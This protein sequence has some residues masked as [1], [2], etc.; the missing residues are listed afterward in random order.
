MSNSSPGKL[1]NH[2]FVF[3]IF[4]GQ[5]LQISTFID[6]FIRGNERE[7]LDY[8]FCHTLFDRSPVLRYI[9]LVTFRKP[10][11]SYIYLSE[12]QLLRQPQEAAFV[13]GTYIFKIFISILISFCLFV[14]FLLGQN[15]D[16]RLYKSDF[17][18]F[19]S[20]FSEC[21]YISFLIISD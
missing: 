6:Q 5:I 2:P 9:W 16:F 11:H 18:L 10:T 12:L 19:F 17:S 4:R 3:F 15:V 7:N 8:L 13:G 1:A 21:T 14:C 20:F